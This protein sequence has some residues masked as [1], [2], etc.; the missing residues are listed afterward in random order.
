MKLV[1]IKSYTPRW[2]IFMI[3]LL[4][5]LMSIS[6]AY[7]IRFDLQNLE[8]TII[9]ILVAIPFVL[10][11][12]A[13]SFL[14]FKTYAG[15]IRFTTIKDTE[16]VFWVVFMGSL[17]LALANIIS[18]FFFNAHHIVPFSVIIIDYLFT[19]FMMVLVRLLIK[20]IY[21][22][23]YSPSKMRT[24]AIIL[25]ANN[26]GL[27]TKNVY[28]SDGNRKNRVVAFL[29]YNKN[30][31]GMKLEG[32]TVYNADKIDYLL[33]KYKIANLII[34]QDEPRLEMK[35]R[36]IEK[37]LENGVQILKVP[38]KSQWINGEL[39][40]SQI[41][42]IQIEE[43]LGRETINL[44]KSSIIKDLH[45]KVILVTG[46]AGSIGSEIVRQLT[47]FYPD[48]IILYDQAES[49]LYELELEL[50]EK[51]KFNNFSAEL[52]SINSFFRLDQVFRKYNPSV[53]FHAA[54]YKHV[55]M[56]EYH[57]AEAVMTNVWGTKNLA[58]LAL[59][60]HVKKFVMVS[61]DK[62]VNPTSVMG[63]TKRTAEMY[64][65]SLSQKNAT[66]FI[67]TRF[68]NVLGSNGSVIP[69]F[70]KQIKKGGPVTI[71]H[72]EI[73]RYFMS[74]P[75]ACQLVLQAGT[76]GNGGE[77]FIFNMGRSVKILDLAKK[78]IRLY[79][80]T[81]DKDIKIQITGLRPGEKLYEELL[82]D[83]ENLI[84][85]YNPK[86]LI[87]KVPRYD[88]RDIQEKVQA[89]LDL[90]VVNHFKDAIVEK[91]HSIVP[92]YT[93]KREYNK[94][95]VLYYTKGEEVNENTLGMTKNHPSGFK[96][97]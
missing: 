89:L 5:C 37:C 3:D 44:D 45:G 63:A 71:T 92:E 55:P 26:F 50:R 12:R 97:L 90:V 11:V 41:Q 52:G 53:I 31:A 56:M 43:L 27:I 18:A 17:L 4:I 6:L 32:I 81:L 91:I 62:A 25:G 60:H 72:P 35:N 93:I 79:G 36:L 54:A 33:E 75:E 76:M 85:T 40:Y 59:I 83:K 16:R 64:I 2:I 28:E 80:L 46:A 68:G 10:G 14:F 94:A 66:A 7:F 88:P 84:P 57:P 21:Y 48:K 61:T 13:V 39:R 69:R 47:A 15:T 70:E 8:A 30:H 87:A 38:E 29:D 20:S 78:M 22:E 74:I 95:E 23:I 73:T 67:T 58:D 9:N 19:S 65:Q 34:S 42:N 86:I 49:P 24:N 1:D 96:P 51:Y 77:I 82:G